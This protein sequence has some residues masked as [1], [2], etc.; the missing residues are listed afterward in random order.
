MFKS[1]FANYLIIYHSDEGL[2][3]GNVNLLTHYCGQFTFSTQLFNTKL[4]ANQKKG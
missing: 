2:T 1:L 4:P 3:P